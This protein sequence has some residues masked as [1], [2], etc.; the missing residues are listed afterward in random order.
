MWVTKLLISPVKKDFLLKNN[1]IWL[2]IGISDHCWLIWCPVGG[3]VGGCGTGCISQDTYLL[4]CYLSIY[5]SMHCQFIRGC[6]V[7]SSVFLTFTTDS[8][9]CF[10]VYTTNV[11]T[12]C[13]YDQAFMLDN[14]S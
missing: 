1:Q 8:S 4:Y 11:Y 7:L 9:I 3:L 10:N 6:L 5:L 14:I 13:L 12:T 2:E